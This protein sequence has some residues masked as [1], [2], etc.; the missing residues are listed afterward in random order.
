MWV[1]PVVLRTHHTP[2]ATI[3]RT[4]PGP[5][6]G[7][8]LLQKPKIPLLYMGSSTKRHV[9]ECRSRQCQVREQ[10]GSNNMDVSTTGVSIVTTLLFW[11]FARTHDPHAHCCGHLRK[12][13]DVKYPDVSYVPTANVNSL[14][15]TPRSTD[16][17]GG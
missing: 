9:V 12:R 1:C 2:R 16:T 5:Y 13:W 15:D 6:G 17:R 10:C 11:K 4:K 8:S 14:R 3:H 7:F